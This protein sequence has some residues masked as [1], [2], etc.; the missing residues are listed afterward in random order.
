MDDQMQMLFS[1]IKLEMEKQTATL[2]ESITRG[3]LEE[4]NN[5]LKPILEE[6]Q[7]L[8][9]EI[10][11]LNEKLKHLESGKKANNLIFY[12]FEES[13]DNTN[14]IETIVNTLKQSGM[15]INKRDINK[16]F[17]LG[18]DKGKARPILVNML[19]V[20]K[21]NEVLRNRKSLPKTVFVKEDFSKEVLEKRRELIPQLKEE[22][23][24]GRIAFIQHDKL[25]VKD[26]VGTSRDKRKRE[27]SNSPKTP[28]DVNDV[29]PKIN[30]IN[31]FE[32]MYR[33]RSQ[34]TSDLNKQ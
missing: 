28:T 34:S 25:I 15:E 31:A 12:G 21:R 10:E 17:R 26:D 14:I 5:K 6:N 18:K 1:K 7:H 24:K 30:K 11:N 9:Q 2:T 29:R 8:K 3:I 16:A 33:N 13:K 19:N 4:M 22:R 20:W 32:R 23:K 27:Q